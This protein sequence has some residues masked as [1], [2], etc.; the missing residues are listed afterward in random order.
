MLT[1]VLGVALFGAGCTQV[2]QAP[3]KV[4]P[5]ASTS[6]TSTVVQSTAT[7][8]VTSDTS[9]WKLEKSLPDIQFSYP[10]ELSYQ[11]GGDMD[12][13]SY[14]WISKG[15]ENFF[16]IFNHAMFKCK[17]IDPAKCDIG[18]MIPAASRDVFDNAVKS[19]REN[20]AYIA[21]ADVK[22]GGLTGKQFVQ[23]DQSK[24]GE[25]RTIVVISTAKHVYSIEDVQ[26][27]NDGKQLFEKFLT[28]FRVK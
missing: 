23:K 14:S 20:P 22:V 26:T 13:G 3:E 16:Q 11:G 2:P 18:T 27:S 8:F 17:F 19:L 4:A 6:S 1:L 5:E 25:A 12:H 7:V 21:G 9:K 15:D 28:T 10:P 24:E